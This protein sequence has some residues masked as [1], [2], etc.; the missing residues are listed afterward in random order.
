MR[1]GVLKLTGAGPMVETLE[2]EGWERW[3]YT[4]DNGVSS[5]MP[6]WTMPEALLDNP[7]EACG[8]ARRALA[9]L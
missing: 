8:W 5:S 9:A 6:Y 4:R 1:D 7:D 3:T 2:G